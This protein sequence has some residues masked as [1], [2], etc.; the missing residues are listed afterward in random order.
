[1]ITLVGLVDTLTEWRSRR[2]LVTLG[3]QLGADGLLVVAAV[4]G[5]AAALDQHAAAVRDILAQA[6]QADAA[7]TLSEQALLAGYARNLLERFDCSVRQVRRHATGRWTRADWLALR[8]LAVCAMSRPSQPD[9][10]DTAVAD[11]VQPG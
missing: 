8:L 6:R 3:K 1:M 7:R 5:L 9:R 11:R 2:W 4:P 10:V